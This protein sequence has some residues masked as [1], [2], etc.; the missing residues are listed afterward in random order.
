MT[1]SNSPPYRRF[2][3]SGYE[4]VTRL[5]YG[6][7]H[8]ADRTFWQ[9]P[10]A[11]MV[12]SS[13]GFLHLLTHK[14]P[15]Q[16][17]TG[18]PKMGAGWAVTEREFE[19]GTFEI[20]CKLPRGKRLWPAFWGLCKE[21]WPPEIDIFEGYSN[22]KGNYKVFHFFNPFVKYAVETNAWYGDYDHR[23]NCGAKQTSAIRDDPSS[24]FEY[25]K[26]VWNPSEMKVFFGTKMV[27]KITEKKLLADFKKNKMVIAINNATKETENDEVSDFVVKYF[28]YTPL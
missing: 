21:I 4:W 1:A 13:T 10:S 16:F 15:R 20:C 8:Q 11:V 24:R 9:D 12:D 7:G 28:S 22:K 5:H 27:R 23:K 2:H 26:L 6:F 25:Y 18:F 14:N 19:F 17:I 3:W